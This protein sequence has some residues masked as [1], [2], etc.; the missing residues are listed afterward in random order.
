MVQV[1]VGGATGLIGQ[2]LT[3]A[4]RDS[5][6]QIRRLTRRRAA[7]PGE[8]TWDPLAGTLDHT[9]LEGAD[10]VVNLAGRRIA[11]GR[12]T[13][14]A[15][16]EIVESRVLT[17]RLLVR[18]LAQVA[19]AHRPPVFISAS[20]IGIYGDRGDETLTEVSPPGG[21]FMADVVRAWEA[22]ALAAPAGVRVVCARF[23]LILTR[24]GGFLA[25][26]LPIFRLG[27]GGPLGSGRQWWS[28]VHLDDVIAAV[29]FAMRTPTLQ[30][31]VNVVS[32]QPV[33][34]REFTRVLAGV[35]RRPAILPTPAVAVRLLLGRQQA[36]E[37]ILSS[38]RV[39]PA[40]LSEQGF[41]FRWTDLRAALHDL[42][43]TAPA[44]HSHV[45]KEGR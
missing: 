4:L 7:G 27:V 2:A 22:E 39:M 26:I 9:A 42:L 35:L 31:P 38:Q 6:M 16:R 36:D 10:A 13:E 23:G 41:A 3:A 1:V 19:P 20:A 5:G 25:P 37:L 28:W 17:T 32:P 34:N 44:M 11:P 21:G 14:A 43:G 29:Q 24:T 33:R 8:I 30:G 40:R 18:A 15:R 45:H 12:W